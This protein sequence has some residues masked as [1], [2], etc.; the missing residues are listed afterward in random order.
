MAVIIQEDQDGNERILEGENSEM[1]STQRP[2]TK[3]DFD[4]IRSIHEGSED[5]YDYDLTLSENLKRVITECV[6]VY[7]SE[8]QLPLI[9]AFALLP[10]A[11]ISVAPVGIFHGSSGSGKS[12][13]TSIIGNLHGIP[14]LSSNSTYAAIRNALNSQ[15][16]LDLESLDGEK[17]T[18]LLFDDCKEHSFNEDVFALFRCGYDRATETIQIS[19]ERAGTNLTFRCFAPKVFST[20]SGFPFD[21]KYEEL[22]RR[23][24]VFWCKRSEELREYLDPSDLNWDSFRGEFRDKWDNPL[25]LGLYKEFTGFIKSLRARPKGL[26]PSQWKISK[27]ILASLVFNE[28][29]DK[30]DGVLL[31]RE[32]WGKFK[33]P[34]S[35]LSLLLSQKIKELQK[36][37]E[38][39]E[40]VAGEPLKFEIPPV[41]INS[42]IKNAREN[43]SLNV[44]PNPYLINE[45]MLGLGFS[46]Q[47][48]DQGVVTWQITR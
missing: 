19:S 6:S 13:L 41:L 48:N 25:N 38:L 24:F 30:Q 33:K 14:L 37:H 46:L 15:R 7:D 27:P 16:W 12:V 34:Q 29:A 2:G 21:A 45:E 9:T 44:I 22:I 1:Q 4:L 31:L 43:G 23:S 17:H 5:L 42:L 40:L 20:V 10:S 3:V 18:F 28:I 26:S 11:L 36:E 8:I 35:A 32:Y 47:M 39:S